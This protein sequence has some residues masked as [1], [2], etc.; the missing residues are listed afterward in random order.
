MPFPAI[1]LISSFWPA[2]MPFFRA[3]MVHGQFLV[4]FQVHITHLIEY[5]NILCQLLLMPLPNLSQLFFNIGFCTFVIG[6]QESDF[7]FSLLN[8]TPASLFFRSCGAVNRT[9]L[10]VPV[11][12]LQYHRTLLFFT[13]LVIDTENPE[14]PF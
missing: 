2:P 9:I 4:K 14:I 13:F 12:C 8:L 7:L 10:K 1:L 6:D 11:S 5:K 3:I